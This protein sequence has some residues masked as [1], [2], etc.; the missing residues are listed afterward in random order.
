MRIGEPGIDVEG[1]VLVEGNEE[2][3]S[4]LPEGDDCKAVVALLN[5]AVENHPLVRELRAKLRMKEAMLAQK[6][7]EIGRLQVA[8]AF[9]LKKLPG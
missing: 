9:G 3:G 4:V 5:Y 6:D 8:V 7:R 2:R 1:S